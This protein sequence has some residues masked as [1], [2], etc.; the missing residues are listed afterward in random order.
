V[1]PNNPALAGAGVERVGF[2][3]IE[4]RDALQHAHRRPQP[5]A[6]APGIGARALE[7]HATHLALQPREPERARLGVQHGLDAG[8]ARRV[9]DAAFGGWPR[10]ARRGGGRATMPAAAPAANVEGPKVP[11]G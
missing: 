2:G 11:Q 7:A 5:R 8:R 6:P 10:G 4:A 1:G 3:R 9:E